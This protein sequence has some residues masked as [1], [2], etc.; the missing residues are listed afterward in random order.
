MNQKE[1]KI[2]SNGSLIVDYVCTS[3]R[4]VLNLN[5]GGRTKADYKHL[6]DLEKEMLKRGMLTVEQI[7]TLNI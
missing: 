6:R 2:A 1:I 3:N 5:L 7:E 4:F